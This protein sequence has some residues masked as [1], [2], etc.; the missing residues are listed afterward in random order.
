MVEDMARRSTPESDEQVELLVADFA[1]AYQHLTV[2]EEELPVLWGHAFGQ[3]ILFSSLCVGLTGAPQVW[4]R[5]AAFVSRVAA[6]ISDPGTLKLQTFVDDPL[7]VLMGGERKVRCKEVGRV[8]VLWRIFGFRLSWGKVK[9]GNS[10]V[11]IGWMLTLSAKYLVTTLPEKAATEIK[12]ILRKMSVCKVMGLQEL[13]EATGKLTWATSVLRQAAWVS[14][15]LWGIVA[16]EGA[17]PL[18]PAA[19]GLGKAARKV[20]MKRI[21][22]A[23]GWLAAILEA[24]PLDLRVVWQIPRPDAVIHIWVDACP[25]GIGGFMVERGTPRFW[26]ASPIRPGWHEI[27]ETKKEGSSGQAIWEALGLFMGTHLFA[28]RVAG[29]YVRF[30]VRNDN[31]AVVA[32]AVKRSSGKKGLERH[33]GA[34][35][36]GMAKERDSRNCHSPHSRTF[37]RRGR[38]IVASALKGHSERITS[39]VGEGQGGVRARGR[40]SPFPALGGSWLQLASSASVA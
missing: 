33:W 28:S 19:G 32:L 12:G 24:H 31:L 30:V 39:V 2:A 1:D 4:C 37:E 5:L 14:R 11:W 8:L 34:H 3:F 29:Q 21:E 13:R 10:L 26:F 36:P 20:P 40:P 18:G 17:R 22:L 23:V 38:S 16:D 15:M 25:E 27:F 35:Q 7:F 9:R 6:A